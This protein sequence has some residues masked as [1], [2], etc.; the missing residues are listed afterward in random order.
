MNHSEVEFG[1]ERFRE[2]LAADQST[3]ADQLVDHLLEELS[4]WAARGP[5][6]ELDDDI[7]VVAIHTQRAKSNSALGT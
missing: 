7:T 4:R 2:Y 1:T 3:S 6:E 5:A